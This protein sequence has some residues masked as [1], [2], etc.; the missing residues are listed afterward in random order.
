MK[1]R[2]HLFLITALML[3][4]TISTGWVY[5]EQSRVKPPEK[6]ETFL[7]N[8]KNSNLIATTTFAYCTANGNNTND[9]YISKVQLGSIDNVST[10]G[11]GGYT[12]FTSI[13]TNLL[14]GSSQTITIT[15]T[16]T[17]TV[18][19][20]AYKVWID[21]NQNGVFT[22]ANEEVFSQNPTQTSPVTGTFTIPNSALDGATRMRIVL[23]YNTLPSSCGSFDYGEV[24]DYTV[25][26]GSNGGGDTQAPSVPTNVTASN[27]GATSADLTWTAST[28][29]VGVA[30]YEIFQGATSIGTS[31]TT[32]YSVTG[33][34][35]NTTYSF[36]IKAK[37]GAGNT[38]GSST[39]V[40]VTTT[41]T[42]V[43]YCTANGNNT[44]DEYIGKVQLGSIDNVSTAGTGGYT[45]FTSISTNLLKGA[46]QTITIT[47]I[48]A[49]TVYSEAYKVWIDYNQNGVFTDA[50]EEVFSQ[51]PTQTTPVTGTFIVPN[52]AL[53][54]ATRMRV[55]LRYNTLPSSCGSFD[56]GEVE[57]YTVVIGSN[58][59]GDTQAPSV[60]TN[61][62]ASN[63]GATSV[64][65]SWT[66]STDNVGVTAYE[67][68]QGATSV[69]AST[70]AN[71]TVTGLTANTT[72]SFTIKAKDAAG[73]VSA[74]STAVNVTTTSTPGCTGITTFPYTES[75]ESGFGAWINA[76]GDDIEWTRDSGGTP[77]NGTGPT[78]GQDGAFYL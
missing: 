51:N 21:Y 69:G 62:T 52:G 44:N 37:D 14:K 74:S 78:T 9:E 46:S 70:T 1:F 64:D 15:P 65:L 11:T 49:G 68:F 4:V 72:Y 53:D 56:Y 17:G 67:I 41:T 24:E 19:S 12:D 3:I 6:E 40:N 18:Y 45:D 50:N 54:G 73:N 39:A 26:L 8:V 43:S 13:S 55:V 36:T 75:F 28:D 16:W 30:A 57:D 38:S 48:W 27:I 58:G 22:D 29:N 76:S 20:E 42:T 23:R 35:A 5:K 71:Y 32:N 25:V 77:S 59:G 31:T 66:A 34:T 61:V 33:L 10:A 2:K 7:S 47:P 63:I 60:P